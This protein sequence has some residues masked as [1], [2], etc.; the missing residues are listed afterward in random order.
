MIVSSKS[1][2]FKQGTHTFVALYHKKGT[3]KFTSTF[4]PQTAHLSSFQRGGYFVCLHF[5]L[6]T[7]VFL[8]YL[9]VESVHYSLSKSYIFHI[10][11]TLLYNSL[12]HHHMV[13]EEHNLFKCLSTKIIWNFT[14]LKVIASKVSSYCESGPGWQYWD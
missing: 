4:L 3:K 2:L 12:I 13:I 5:S 8:T 9:L 6:G 10:P 7:S 1:V 11:K 14:K